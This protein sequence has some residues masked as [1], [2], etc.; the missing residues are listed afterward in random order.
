MP[1]TFEKLDILA[2]DS[3]YDLACAC[4]TS[5]Q[6]RRRRGLD[7]KW[8][9]PVPLASGGHGIMLKTLLSNCCTSDCGYCPLRLEGNVRRCSLTPEETAAAFI[10]ILRKR[11]LIGIFISSGIVG[12][13]DA[14]MARL[15]AVAEILRYKYHYR[16]Y[17][18]LKVIPGASDAAV[19]RAVK[20]ASAVSLNIETPGAHHFAALSQ[21]KDYQTDIIDKLK[22]MSRLTSRGT[23]GARVTVTTQ[24]VVGAAGEC[25]REIVRY[26]DG[27]YNRLKLQRIYF[28]AYQPGLG[29]RNLPGEH[30]ELGADDR[31]VREHRLYQADFL[32]RRYGFDASELQFDERGNFDLSV[33]PK[34]AWAERHR[35]LFP[36][37][38]NRA[39]REMLLRVPGFGPV[40]VDRIVALRRQGRI[41]SLEAAGIRGAQLKHAAGFAVCS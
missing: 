32:L 41:S 37:D 35:H 9:Y 34:R 10:E 13:P 23:P 40:T 18:H 20:V 8:L 5:S 6:D 27:L 7:G 26:M 36:L 28:S 1:S 19:E 21:Y 33:D 31:F 12:S 39:D 25:D 38:V 2:A 4:G 16:G 29:R 17:I 24:F 15:L 22:L 30:F 3:Q 14:T 11:F